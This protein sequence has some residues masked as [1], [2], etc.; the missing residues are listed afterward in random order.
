MFYSYLEMEHAEENLLFVEEVENLKLI[1]SIPYKDAPKDI[2]FFEAFTKIMSTY[3]LPGSVHEVNLPQPLVNHL[4]AVTERG[5][6][7]LDRQTITQEI[8]KAEKQILEILMGIFPRF[9]NSPHFQ[10]YLQPN[11]A[12]RSKSLRETYD[13]VSQRLSLVAPSSTVLLCEEHTLTRLFICRMLSRKG[14]YVETANTGAEALEKLNT[15]VFS[16]VLVSYEISRVEVHEL[17]KIHKVYPKAL[18]MNSN[19]ICMVFSTN[20]HLKRSL[21]KSGYSNTLLKPF[22]MDDFEHALIS[23]GNQLTKFSHS[24]LQ[25]LR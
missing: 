3:I 20:A 2:D 13:S 10:D 11:I 8:E 1:E 12:I 15:H 25:L 21:F 23:S 22:S 6:E 4:M 7:Y 5:L 18:N 24:I 9:Q 14:Y 19:F 16:V 17:V